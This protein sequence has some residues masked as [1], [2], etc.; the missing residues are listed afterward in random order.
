MAKD[1]T[2]RGGARVGSGKKKRPIEEMILEGR[3][4][5]RIENSTEIAN[6][7]GIDVPDPREYL[8]DAQRVNIP[9]IA[10]DVFKKMYEW[11]ISLGCE[12]YI[13]TDLIEMYSQSYARYMQMERMISGT[14]FL[15]KHPT[16]GAAINSPYVTMSDLYSKQA[17]R[18]YAMIEQRVKERC[19]GDFTPFNIEEQ[20]L[21]DLL[22]KPINKNVGGK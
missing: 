16:T 3:A 1:G 20:E 17:I 19:E 7:E 4:E 8:S 18:V 13:F 6:I 9:L 2:L 12:K 14:G 11:L 5:P 10:K 15:A 21:E 22:A